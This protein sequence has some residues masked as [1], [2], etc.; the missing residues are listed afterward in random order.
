[1]FVMFIV[2]NFKLFVNVCELQ[3]CYL[4]Y[5]PPP[6]LYTIH[7][8]I[9]LYIHFIYSFDFVFSFKFCCI[10]CKQRRKKKKKMRTTKHQQRL[11]NSYIYYIQ[12]YKIYTIYIY[13]LLL[14]L[15][16]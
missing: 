6:P 15:F 16:I 5:T 4:I 7:I 11:E 8:Y 1:M 9:D 10:C 3:K 12:R 14:Y 13:D 2:T